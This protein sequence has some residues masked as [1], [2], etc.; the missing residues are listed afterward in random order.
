MLTQVSL[1]V[2]WSSRA[3]TAEECQVW[4]G[5]DLV[6]SFCLSIFCHSLLTSSCDYYKF[7]YSA[8]PLVPLPAVPPHDSGQSWDGFLLFWIKGFRYTIVQTSQPEYKSEHWGQQEPGPRCWFSCRVQQ[9]ERAV[10][11]LPERERKILFTQETQRSQWRGRRGSWHCRS[12]QGIV[13]AREREIDFK[14]TWERPK[15]GQPRPC[16]LGSEWLVFIGRAV[17]WLC[18]R[19]WWGEGSS[20]NR[21]ARWPRLGSSPSYEA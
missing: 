21:A 6:L 9:F 2:L 8:L 15:E 14:Q 11:C 13:I 17:L 19:W 1:T 5:Y 4:R 20:R 12:H 7:S 18:I 10:Q 3:L 16:C